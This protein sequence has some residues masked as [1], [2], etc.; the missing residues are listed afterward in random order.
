MTGKREWEDRTYKPFVGKSPE[1]DV[2]FESL[3][4]IPVQPLYTPED[5]ADK[6]YDERLGYPG[7]YPFT[8]GV[9]PTMYRGRLWTMR[10]FAGFGRP[11]DTNARFKYL[12]EQGQTG[13]STA[14]DMPALMGYD[15]DHPRARGEVGKEGVSISTL[16]DFERLF[17]DIPLGDVT[18]SMTINCT[19]SVALAMY[20]A[21]AEKQGV[22]WDRIGG[23]MQNDMLKEFI[24]Q[25][26]WIC[27]P[28][29]AVRIVADM[30]E[31]TSKH[32]PRFNPVSISGYHIREAGSTAVQELAFTLADG[33]GYV[34]S[35]LARG[36]DID[37]FAPRLS[38]F[39]D[40]H[41]DF[42]EEIAKLRAARRMWARFMKERYGARKLESMRLRTHTQTAGVSAT[43]QQP[44]N[45]IARVAIQALAAVLGGA[46]SLHT[47]SYDETWALPTEDAVTVALRTQQIIAEET[48]TA[49][50]VDP[51]GGSY[52]LEK[53]TDQMEAAAMEYIA[54]IDAMGGM[55]RAIDN[56]FPQK[57]IADAAYRYQLMED[58]GQK[59]T[60]GVNKYAMREDKPINFLRI[61]ESV[62]TEQI[63][64]VG[65]FKA[66]RDM[67]KVERRLKQLAEACGN[68]H[69]VMPVLIDAVKDYA[70]L[71]EISDVY[72]QVFGLY[73]EPIIF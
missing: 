29:P 55:I 12:L 60:V 1:R 44:L 70:S 16:D 39:F 28:E 72:R 25:K 47:N 54:Q 71:G 50:T 31:F 36:L 61:D 56:G 64:R 57:E 32:V 67:A 7:Q 21:I 66:A 49:L 33:L 23:T 14:F 37:A 17:A 59:V 30:I 19:A 52:F 13:L 69:N 63:E 62:E 20:L 35:A 38:F 58:R 5:V 34:E 41:N 6:S 73:R 51:L 22:A 10:M 11:E 2:R 26:E 8:R 43:A 68:G 53:L 40:I 27:P 9:Y 3:S 24:A 46:Q 48:G 18:T 45:N 42:F 65:R 4:G 15:A